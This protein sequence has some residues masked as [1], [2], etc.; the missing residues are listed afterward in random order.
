MDAQLLATAGAF[1]LAS[2]A[3]LNTTLPLLLVGVLARIGLIGLA[4]P[5]D[6]LSSDPAIVGL[7]LLSALEFSAD[8][9]PALD[10]LTQALQWPLTLTAGAVLFASQNSVI[11]EVSP[12][13]TI[14]VGVLLAGSVHGVR[15]LARPAVNVSTMGLGAPVVSLVEDTLAV[16]LTILALLFP[17]LVIPLLVLLGYV[18]YRA[19]KLGRRLLRRKQ[20]SFV[21]APAR[22]AHRT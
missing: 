2:A 1:G 10:S 8:K 15:S 18:A 17:L 7:A 9:I 3:G 4:S 13:L 12:A 5:Y 19:I 22:T 16:L 11:T 14:L 21:T 6:A 20:P